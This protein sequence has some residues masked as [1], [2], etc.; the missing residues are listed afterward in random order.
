VAVLVLVCQF[1]FWRKYKGTN[2]YVV[3]EHLH[4]LES[5]ARDDEPDITLGIDEDVVG[6]DDAGL[7]VWDFSDSDNSDVLDEW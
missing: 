5:L 4:Q 6:L 1:Y 2:I 7:V 3:D